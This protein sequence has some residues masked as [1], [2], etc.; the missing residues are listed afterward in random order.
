[1]RVA[2]TRP[3]DQW[4][5]DIV[6]PRSP[7]YLG[8]QYQHVR[9]EIEGLINVLRSAA[10]P[11]GRPDGAPLRGSRYSLHELRWP[12][13]DRGEGPDAGTGQ[14]VIRVFYGLAVRRFDRAKGRGTVSVVLL[15]GNKTPAIL[16]S[17]SH[18]R[19]YDDHIRVAE[20]RLDAW[21]A[22]HPTFVPVRSSP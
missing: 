11:V 17:G 9:D 18:D 7:V 21:C 22:D 15:G 12:P 8:D 6:D 19:W 3:F 4:L 2:R 5:E 10:Q 16:R 20:A 1:M 14:P 13:L